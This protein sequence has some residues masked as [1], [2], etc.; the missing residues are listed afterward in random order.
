MYIVKEPNERN[1]SSFFKVFCNKKVTHHVFDREKYEALKWNEKSV[2][3]CSVMNLLH[4]E[5]RDR[6][7]AEKHYVGSFMV[8]L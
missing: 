5:K 8:C 2:D 4:K 6:K 3:V 7:L 1:K